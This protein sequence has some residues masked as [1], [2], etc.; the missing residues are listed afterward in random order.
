MHIYATLDTP[1]VHIWAVGMSWPDD[2]EM[3]SARQMAAAAGLGPTTITN[4]AKLPD[5]PLPH[6]EVGGKQMFQWGELVAF[7]RSRPGLPAAAK[8]AARLRTHTD[9]SAAAAPTDPETLKAI[10]R[11]VKA[12]A[13]SA[14]RAALKGA[15]MHLEIVQELCDTITALD[16][17][18][19][20]ALAPGTLND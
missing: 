14:S 11:D 7:A 19:T 16:D 20:Q 3:L 6:H 2:S 9:G 10:A 8:L 18:L 4:W 12:A 13:A 17:A 15:R 1:N 5:Q